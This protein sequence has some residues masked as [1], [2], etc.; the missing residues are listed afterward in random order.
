M[1]IELAIATLT[2]LV[3][4]GV[5]ILTAGIPWAFSVHGRLSRI[6]TSLSQNLEQGRRLEHIELRLLW[7]E[8]QREGETSS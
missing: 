2:C 8:A 1:T 4:V 6:E 7:M 5:T 3:G